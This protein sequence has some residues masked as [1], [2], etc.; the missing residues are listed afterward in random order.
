ME[1]NFSFPLK[2]VIKRIN[3]YFFIEMPTLC[4]TIEK[5]ELTE[6]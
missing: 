3:L 2:K 1:E 5:V 6:K 4:H